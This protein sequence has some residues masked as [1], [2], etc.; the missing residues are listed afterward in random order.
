[1]FSQYSNLIF[2]LQTHTLLNAFLQMNFNMITYSY[3]SI[4]IK[5]RTFIYII[6]TRLLQKLY[7]Y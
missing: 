4:Y 5:Y 3:I 7:I 6:H 2:T 1:M